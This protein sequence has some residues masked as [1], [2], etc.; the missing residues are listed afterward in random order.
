MKNKE[1][2]AIYKPRR[3][4]SEGTNPADSLISDFWPP[5]LWKYKFLLVKPPGLWYFVTTA[6]ANS[7]Q[8]SKSPVQLCARDW[9]C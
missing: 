8:Y 2:V 7:P 4:A 5:E 3:E 1:K 9:V 6:G